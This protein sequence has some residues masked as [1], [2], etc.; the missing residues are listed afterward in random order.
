LLEIQSL[1]AWYGN[2]QVLKGLDLEVGA[3]EIVTLIGANGA[4]KSTT[5]K[6]VSGLLRPRRGVIRYQ[7]EEIQRLPTHEIIQ[8]GIVTI[9]EGRRLFPDL[10][11]LENLRLGAY[12]CRSARVVAQRMDRVFTLFPDLKG[13]ERQLAASFSGGQQ[14]MIAIGRGLMAEPKLL[15][16]DEPTLG[17][18]PLMTQK[19][20]AII[21][22][23]QEDGIT[24]LLIEQNANMALRLANRGYVLETGKIVME[25]AGREL[26][27]NDTI[28]RAYLGI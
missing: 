3:G 13:R 1:D 16:M 5:L 28:R 17:L 26:F 10:D 18:S 14:Q 19:V 12:H 23:I 8:R 15:M 9:M 2:V 22:A 25:G 6:C 4:G 7:G 24:I 21:K 11:V 20:A 27:V